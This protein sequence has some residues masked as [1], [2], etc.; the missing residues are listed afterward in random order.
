[1]EGIQLETN[2]SIVKRFHPSQVW[3]YLVIGLTLGFISG[4]VVSTTGLIAAAGLII[5]LALLFFLKPRRLV[6]YS[7]VG[8]LLALVR[9]AQ[10]PPPPA[11]AYFVGPQSFI[12]TV[13]SGPRI[14]GVNVRYTVKTDSSYKGLVEVLAKPY[15]SYKA[16]DILQIDCAEV[17]AVSFLYLQHKS[18]WRQ[19]AWPKIFVIGQA[20][21]NIKTGLGR[22]RWLAG[23][24][25]NKLLPMPFATLATGMLWGDDT[26]LPDKLVKNFRAT[27]TTHLLAVSGFNVSVL[28]QI[29]FIVLISFALRRQTA[30]VA[31]I[32][33]VGLFVIFTG[34]EPSV[35]RAGIMGSV[36]L[37]AGLVGRPADKANV[38]LGT[39]AVMLSFSPTLIFDLGWQLSFASM[40]GLSTVGPVLRK[41][42]D[43]LP[44]KYGLRDSLS[45]T[46]AAT[47]ATLPIIVW[48]IGQVSLV[49]PLANVLIGPVVVLVFVLGL[50][51]VL[52]P[53][54]IV[55]L[56]QPLVWL[57]M[58]VLA[59]VMWVA[60]TLA[61]LPGAV[62][63][64][65]AVLV[66][67][68]VILC[69]GGLIWWVRKNYQN[70][71]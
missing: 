14:R 30:S 13:T 22:L 19:C 5:S 38:L 68:V 33:L 37:L 65:A 64:P 29:I 16:G 51:L 8:F 50:P 31:A 57:L 55:W 47:L 61:A 21:A 49:S 9:W 53:N 36:V 41:K 28:V 32:G 63:K 12:A 48:Q 2:F 54:A 58:A 23:V 66:W 6:I 52:L 20:K 39:A 60:N 4:A 69:Y 67:P 71:Q 11:P 34:A 43:W 18:V 1:M 42:F 26:G 27:G 17:S 56:L 35:V 44:E 70:N 62:L 59:Y 25:I 3:R 24:K 45:Q 10:V 15:P 40:V 46:L 7:L